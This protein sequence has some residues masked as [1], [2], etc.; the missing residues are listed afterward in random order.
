MKKQ[1]LFLLSILSLSLISCGT[2]PATSAG[3]SA[4]SSGE[5][6]SN[7]VTSVLSSFNQS[8][9]ATATFPFLSSSS[10]VTPIIKNTYVE[11]GCYFDYNNFSDFTDFGLVN[12]AAGAKEGV[13]AGVYKYTQTNNQLTLGDNVSSTTSD[14]RTLYN[15]PSDIAKDAALYAPAFVPQI[16]G[17]TYGKFDLNKD[18]QS[19]DLLVSFAKGLGLYDVYASI[20]NLTLNYATLYFA[21]SGKIFTVTFYCQYNGGYDS[22]TSAVSISSLGT[23]KIQAITNYFAAS[24]SSSASSAAASSSTSA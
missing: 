23:A 5:T 11:Q 6:G 15:T 20:A 8:L 3:S 1:A 14:F 24:T 16:A 9:V 21:Q 22:I 12:V 4:S 13:A 19:K 17:T 18:G 10:K 2:T 7:T